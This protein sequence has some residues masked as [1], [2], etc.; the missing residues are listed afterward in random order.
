VVVIFLLIAA[1]FQ[2][3]WLALAVVSTVPA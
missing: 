3:V 1:N 2:S